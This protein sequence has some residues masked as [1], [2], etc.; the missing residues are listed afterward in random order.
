MDRSPTPD[1]SGIDLGLYVLPEK[2]ASLTSSR[3][4]YYGK[5][6]FC[7]ESF[8]QF[9]RKRSSNRVWQDVL[10]IA[11]EQ[12]IRHFMFWDP[13]TP[14]GTLDLIARGAKDEGLEIHWMAEVK[15]DQLYT[16]DRYLRTLA[17]GGCRMLQFGFESGVQRVLDGMDK[18]NDLERIDVILSKLHDAGIAAG[19]FWFIG[20]PTE[21]ESD[22][23]ETWRF[24]AEREDKVHFHGYVGTFGIGHDV[25]VYKDPGRYDIEI[26]SSPGGDLAFRRRDGRDWD[27]S[28]LHETYFSRS[29][30]VAI[31]SGA[32]LLYLERAPDRA[33]AI[34][35]RRLLGPPSFMPPA[36]ERRS[37]RVPET[38]G[39]HQ[40]PGETR[41]AY[42]GRSG[43]LFMIEPEDR[44]IIDAVR[45]GSSALGG[46]PN[47][48]LERLRRL[49]DR[50]ILAS[51]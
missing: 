5:C 35:G 4:C 43:R 26:L 38:N 36:I 6:T 48:T 51:D 13:L 3:G 12:G 2:I 22:A 10:Q 31:T 46:D 19:V 15:F 49:I 30:L 29:D 45:Q 42:V 16:D 20:F 9:F 21:L 14:P 11:T 34:T 47:G 1:F 17:S 44:A 37:L 50:G 28:P 41:Y 39:F 33:K 27:R 7:P 23:R 40:G 24:L 32:T 8:R 18:G 25:P